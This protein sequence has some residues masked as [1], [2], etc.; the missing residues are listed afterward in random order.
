MIRTIIFIII[1]LVI[2]LSYLGIDIKQTVESE[3]AQRN[4]GYV[5]AVIITIWNKY[6]EP[7]LEYLWEV[8]VD[9]IWNPLFKNKLGAESGNDAGAA[10]ATVNDRDQAAAVSSGGL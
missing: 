6:I 2:V 5:K 8:F 1:I 4:I 3:M 9:N 7:P 10:G